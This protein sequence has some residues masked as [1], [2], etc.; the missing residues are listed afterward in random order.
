MISGGILPDPCFPLF[1]I[2]FHRKAKIVRKTKGLIPPVVNAANGNLS[3][4]IKLIKRAPPDSSSSG[5]SE[6]F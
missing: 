6:V 5:M 3:E 2:I 4:E 1:V